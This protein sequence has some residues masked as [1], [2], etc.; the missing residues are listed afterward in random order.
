MVAPIDSATGLV[1]HS[2]KLR[3]PRVRHHELTRDGLLDQAAVQDA[4]ILA[5]NAPAG[6]THCPNYASDFS[7]CHPSSRLHPYPGQ[8]RHI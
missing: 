4:E 8:Y 3:P 1:T 7:H 2:A 6:T 5:V